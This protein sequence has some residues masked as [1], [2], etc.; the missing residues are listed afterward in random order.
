MEAFQRFGCYNPWQS[1]A[2]MEAHGRPGGR[3]NY[4]MAPFLAG[5]SPEAPGQP[6]VASSQNE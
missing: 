6:R 4:D 2:V 1:R 5:G 3:R